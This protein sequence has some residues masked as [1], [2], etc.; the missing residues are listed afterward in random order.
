MQENASAVIEM[1][2]L[3][4]LAHN[5]YDPFSSNPDRSLPLS[6]TMCWRMP[7][8]NLLEVRGDIL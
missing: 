2:V 1:G 8:W 6:P 7:L 3:A 5:N 4:E